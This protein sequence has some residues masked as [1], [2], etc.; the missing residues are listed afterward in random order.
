MD[1]EDTL[2]EC[3]PMRKPAF[4]AYGKP[5][6]ASLQLFSVVVKTFFVR[7]S[8]KP[9]D[10]FSHDRAHYSHAL[11]KWGYAGIALSVLLFF[12]LSVIPS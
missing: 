7:P 1:I 8:W 5:I 4:F 3:C 10:M 11:K 6:I 9:E 12:C 2:G